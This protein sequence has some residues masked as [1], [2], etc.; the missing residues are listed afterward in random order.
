LPIVLLKAIVV[1]EGSE[2]KHEAIVRSVGDDSVTVVLSP[3]LSCEGCQAESSCG[4]TGKS[5]K[6]VSIPGTFKFHPGDKVIVSMKDSQGY[7]A[8][9]LGYMLPLILVVSTL[10]I[11]LSF[12]A[13]ELLS[14]LISFGILIPYYIILR[15]FRNSI[16]RKF[17]FKINTAT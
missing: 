1:K 12:E 6:I 7:T 3:G 16:G 13:G 5:D 8:L 14:G 10:I 9:F 4:M 15:I 2:I 17:S 11:L